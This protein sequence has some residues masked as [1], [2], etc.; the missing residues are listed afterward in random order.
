[1]TLKGIGR[2]ILAMV[3]MD[4][5]FSQMERDLEVTQDKSLKPDKRKKAK[6]A[7]HANVKRIRK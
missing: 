6:A 7:R 4:K 3:L 5:S 2:V 1:M